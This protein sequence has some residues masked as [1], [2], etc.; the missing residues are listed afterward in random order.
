MFGIGSVIKAIT[1]LLI[2][3][4]IGAGGWYL[5]NL[6]ADLAISEANN[7]KLVEATQAQTALIEGMRADIQ[8]IQ[9]TNRQLA[10]DNE[11]QRR[12]VETLNSKFSKRDFG[13]LAAERPAAIEKLVNRGTVNA[14]RCL[15][16][17]SGAPLNDKEKNA[18]T[19][20]EANR[21]C[22]ALID[23]NYTEPTR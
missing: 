13:A 1:T 10:E 15:E 12:D 19:P 4:S 8:Q 21:E 17:A 3:L 22:P 7:A 20:M 11:K 9:E 2:V 18:K 16:L 14:M 6:K 5:M 23:R